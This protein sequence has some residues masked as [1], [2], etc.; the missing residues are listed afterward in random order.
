MPSSERSIDGRMLSF[1]KIDCSISNLPRAVAAVHAAIAQWERKTCIRFVPYTNQKFHLTFFRNTHCWGNVGQVSY[2]KIS[3]GPGCE[4]D[5]VMAHEIGHVVGLYH[6]Q[7]RKDRDDWVKI[8]WENVGRFR[9]AFDLVNNTDAL[10][11]QYDYE[12]I[13]HYPWNAFSANG[14]VTMA[15]KRDTKGKV[16]YKEISKR[17]IELVSK[18]YNCPAIEKMRRQQ[19][20]RL[21]Y[22]LGSTFAEKG[23]SCADTR[24]DCQIWQKAGHCSVKSVQQACPKS[25]NQCGDKARPFPTE[26]PGKTGDFDSW[27]N[28]NHLGI[29][30]R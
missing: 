5:Y 13:M 17:D 24:R 11:S 22:R 25:C 12:S 10:G 19:A 3:V 26:T 20:N 15:P 18:M 1:P 27:P 6:E 9:D 28:N 8:I 7:N 30:I 14:K 4:Y 23:P 29:G 21:R 2:S 16:P